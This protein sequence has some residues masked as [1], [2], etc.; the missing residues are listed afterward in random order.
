MFFCE[1]EYIDQ[2]FNN[3]KVYKCKYCGMT[4]ALEDPEANIICFKR[5]NEIFDKIDNQ[6]RP[7]DQQINSQF[8][9]SG[10]ELALQEFLA[11][12]MNKK[13]SETTSE[14]PVLMPVEDHPSNLCSKEDIDQ[15]LAICQACEHYQNDACML[16]GCTIVREMNFNN[17]LAHKN[18]SCPVGKWGP[19]QN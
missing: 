10:D 14:D 11:K 8:L 3:K 5:H 18:G 16:C 7:A 4:L 17:K 15:R 2:V 9:D 6:N 12:D 1:F 13:I 19:I